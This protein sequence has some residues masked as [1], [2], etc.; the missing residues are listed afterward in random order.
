M[1][2]CFCLSFIAKNIFTGFSAYTMKIQNIP[3]IQYANPNCNN[4]QIIVSYPSQPIGWDTV[5]FSGR[6]QKLTQK[7]K[8]ERAMDIAEHFDINQIYDMDDFDQQQLEGIQYGL[9]TFEGMP[10]KD[11]YFFLSNMGE[12]TIPV[13]RHCS[14]MCPVCSVN[15]GPF[16]RQNK[17]L[18]TRMDF[19]DYKNLTDDINEISERLQFYCHEKELRKQEFGILLGYTEPTTALF[20]DSDCKDVWIKDNKGIVHEFPELNSMLY[21]ATGI[22]GLFDTAGWAPRDTKTQERMERFAEYFSDPE[23]LEEIEQINISLNTYHGIMEKALEYKRKGDLDSYNR[24]KKVYAKNIANAMYTFTPLLDS[25]KYH[26]FR[27]AIPYT[28][29]EIYD[30]YKPDVLCDIEHDVF[31]AL[32]DR[33]KYDLINK[34]YKFVK[35]LFDVSNIMYK[36]KHIFF[37]LDTKISPSPINN[38]FSKLPSWEK[39]PITKE[40]AI[41]EVLKKTNM[42]IDMNGKVLFENDYHVF[43]TDMQLNFNNKYKQT[44]QIYPIPDKRVIRVTE[45]QKNYLKINST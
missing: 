1:S 16:D 22:K 29:R 17:N 36:Q 26:I 6:L 35:N 23:H 43:E 8:L 28:E 41:D 30:D 9:K 2:A 34:N 15:G 4:K 12:V 3:F 24:A 14:G 7:Q 38:I 40:S 10:F 27:K 19:E 11:V 37:E 44:K 5:S 20:R 21:E 33:Y 13:I 45:K 25:D 31:A 18:V 39:K 42:F 32:K